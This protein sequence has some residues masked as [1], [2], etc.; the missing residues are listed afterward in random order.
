MKRRTA[1]AD[2]APAVDGSTTIFLS[3]ELDHEGVEAIERDVQRVASLTTRALVFDTAEVTFV[4]SAGLRLLLQTQMTVCSR[5]AE[6]VMARPADNV[7]RL[8]RLTGLDDLL[9]PVPG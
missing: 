8:L 7:V 4:D 5:G 1:R 3:G 9:G 2:V 6:F